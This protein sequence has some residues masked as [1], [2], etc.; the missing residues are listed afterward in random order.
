MLP[1][2]VPAN[3]PYPTWALTVRKALSEEGHSTPQ[4]IS[5]FELIVGH[6]DLFYESRELFVPQMVNSLARLGSAA[7]ATPEMKK[8]R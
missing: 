7:A 2:Q 3:I 6:P 4:L 5:A 1:R 8:V